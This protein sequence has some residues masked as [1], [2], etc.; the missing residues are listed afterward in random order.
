[1]SFQEIVEN[2]PFF[3]S[4]AVYVAYLW[5]EKK[6][7]RYGDSNNYRFYITK[8]DMQLFPELVGRKTVYLQTD[9]SGNVFEV[10][11]EI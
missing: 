2:S 6:A 9:D 4:Q 3:A 5:S 11:K 8:A 7:Y 1:M 10:S